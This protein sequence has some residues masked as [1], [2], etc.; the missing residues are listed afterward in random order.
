MLIKH[1]FFNKRILPSCSWVMS[2]K[3]MCP[4]KT[5]VN[6]HCSIKSCPHSAWLVFVSQP[7]FKIISATWECLYSTL[8]CSF[9]TGTVKL[10][11][12][13]LADSQQDDY[14]STD[15]LPA[16]ASDH[17]FMTYKLE[18]LKNHWV[19]KLLA[20][21]SS[22]RTLIISSPDPAPKREK[23]LVYIQRFLGLV[24]EF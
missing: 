7:I 8:W 9:G 2:S 18:L 14:F 3:H 22:A 19:H 20:M 16:M 13:S 21:C 15:F 5:I 24:S 12:A 17:G 10:F 6:I 11:E 4:I 23:G 1:I